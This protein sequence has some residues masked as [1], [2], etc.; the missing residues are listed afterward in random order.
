MVKGTNSQQALAREASC[1]CQKRQ[2]VPSTVQDEGDNGGGEVVARRSGTLFELD[3]LNCPVCCHALTVPIFQCDNGHI[4][5]SSCCNKLG[6]KCPNYNCK[7]LSFPIGNYRCRIMER[8]VEA[9]I[10][11]SPNAKHG[12]TDKGEEEEE[13]GENGDVDGDVVIWEAQS[14][15]LFDLHLLDC[16]VCS[17]ALTSPIFQCDN[18]HIACSSCCTELRYKCHSCIFPIGNYPC[19]IMEKVVQA[20]FVPCPNLKHG[21]TERF[22]Y[23]KDLIHEKKCVFAMCYCPQPNCNYRGVCNDLYI[24]YNANHLNKKISN[25]FV[26]D[27]S[28]VTW[29]KISDKILVFQESADG[30]G[31]LVA[32]QCFK[33]PEGLYV[34]V[35]CIAPS[36]P[37]VGEFSYDLSY[38]TPMSGDQHTMTFKSP[39]MKRIQKVSFQTPEKD[40]MLVPYYFQDKRVSLKMN[41]CIHRLKK[42]E[43]GISIR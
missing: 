31:P 11:P 37:G 35:N 1:S 41:I 8:V 15:M 42:D 12:C 14:G 27:R 28:T 33:E 29:M 20:I 24:H 7:W 3:L 40:F 16:P 32:V 19:R 26:C 17:N 13:E 39:E 10:V 30:H 25:Q 2:P 21:C 9:V 38:S 4:A 36:A 23:G 34:T 6:N 18:G 22:S 43:R 5:C